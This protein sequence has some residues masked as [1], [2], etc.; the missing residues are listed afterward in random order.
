MLDKG[1][2]DVSRAFGNDTG[3]KYKNMP[4]KLELLTKEIRDY[5]WSNDTFFV[6]INSLSI[7]K[8]AKKL[9]WKK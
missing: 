6:V 3:Y 7:P 4:I 9:G 2:T 1:Q 8:K 5:N